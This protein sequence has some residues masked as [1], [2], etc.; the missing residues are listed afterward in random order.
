MKIEREVKW[1]TVACRAL[2]YLGM[3]VFCLASW[4]LIIKGCA[5]LAHASTADC[6]L[7]K[8]ADR[9]HFCRAMNIPSRAEC[10]FIKDHDLR[11]ECRG[12]VNTKKG[13]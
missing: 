6:S 9:R 3:L 2:A 5:K 12:R 10:E 13:S 1:S 11:Q 4:G 8:D 7:I